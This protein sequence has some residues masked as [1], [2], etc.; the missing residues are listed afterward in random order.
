MCKRE[1][2]EA[3]QAFE[4]Q[5]AWLRKHSPYYP[6]IMLKHSGGE[7]IIASTIIRQEFEGK[8]YKT[9]LVRRR[10]VPIGSHEAENLIEDIMAHA[11]RILVLGKVDPKCT[12]LSGEP[13]FELDEDQSSEAE[14]LTK[15]IPGYKPLNS[16]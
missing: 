16:K 8:W 9:H 13:M 6:Q 10:V 15:L 5:R 3:N 2:L 14:R 7:E 11:Y 1:I 4:M 12:Y